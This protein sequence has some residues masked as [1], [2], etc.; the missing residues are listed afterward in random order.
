MRNAQVAFEDYC[1]GAKDYLRASKMVFPVT[2]QSYCQPSNQTHIPQKTNGDEQTKRERERARFF[3]R[4]NMTRT[5][6]QEIQYNYLGTG[7]LKRG[8]R[9]ASPAWP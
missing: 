6:N 5:K 7:G 2:L 9:S 8:E 3:S 1:V 4:K